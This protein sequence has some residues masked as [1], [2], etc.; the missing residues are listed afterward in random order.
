MAWIGGSKPRLCFLPLLLFYPFSTTPGDAH[1][2][3]YNFTVNSQP[4]PG[5]PWCVVQGQV[6]G[7]IFLSYDCGRAKIQFTSPLGE[8]VKMTKAWETQTETLR[9]VG[10]LLRE[11][12][13]DVTLENHRVTENGHWTVVDSGGR[14][15]REK[16]E[17][18]RAV[19]NFFKKVSMGDCRAWLRDFLVRWEEMLTTT[20]SPTAAPLRVNSTAT[21]IKHITWILPVLLTSFIMTVF[22]G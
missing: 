10:D 8:E 11:Q 3:C 20:A 12:L 16:W 21:A 22:L 1:S 5:Q 18:D 19:S 7:K 4:R 15:M 14:R 17:K 6:D 13:P 2:L 9:D